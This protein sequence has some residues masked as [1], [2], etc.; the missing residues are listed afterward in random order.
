MF[1]DSYTP[2]IFE[3]SKLN[4]DIIK[5]LK[6]INK[7]N[8][9]NMIINGV[10]GTG[11]YIL[12]LMLLHNIFGKDIYNTKQ[13]SDNINI[14]YSLHHYEI[15]F[16]KN[17]KTTSIIEFIKTISENI[18][19]NSSYNNIIIIKNAQYLDY[20]TIILIKNIIEQK[21]TIN[22]ILLFNNISKLSKSFYN[23]FLNIRIPKLKYEEIQTFIED[24][25]FN[26]KINIPKNIIDNIITS[27][28][29]NI[30]KILLN[31]YKY[32]KTNTIIEYKD[33]ILDDLYNLILK[34]NIH[35]ILKIRE[36]LYEINSKNIDK[37]Y[38][39]KFFFE[40]VVKTIKTPQKKIEFTF[41]TS[42]IDKNL[43]RAYKDLIHLEYF[44]M[45]LNKFIE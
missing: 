33:T 42:E 22:F 5:K 29:H 23:L 35:N 36:T 24:L 39:I 15:I 27:N 45:S 11:K 40:K 34:N 13:Y 12:S 41:F 16:N 43:S 37:K 9:M 26:E 17:I 32:S 4:L 19:I 10:N 8:F 3:E 38:I 2:K 14:C 44:I 28:K 1:Y 7:E 18:N 20:Q 21:N 30:T 6:N 25:T 31:I